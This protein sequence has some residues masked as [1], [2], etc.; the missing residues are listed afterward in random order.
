[1]HA[2]LWLPIALL[3]LSIALWR[4]VALT[5]LLVWVRG[6]AVVVLVRGR[7][8]VVVGLH[9]AGRWA[10]IIMRGRRGLRVL[11]RCALVLR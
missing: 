11:R 4:A 7:A 5:L 9:A 10:G 6:V 3:R 1:V 8:L 2:L